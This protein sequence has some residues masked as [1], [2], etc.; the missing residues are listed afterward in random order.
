MKI[1]ESGMPEET[2]WESFF[3][4]QYIFS[5]L[6]LDSKINDAVEFGSG[7][8]TFTIPAAKIIKGT[9]FALDIDPAMIERLNQRIDETKL[10]N[11]KVINRDFVKEETGLKENSVDY[12]MLF[13]ILHAE[14][15]I[16]LLEESYRILKSNGK[17]GII[18]WIYSETTPRGP[19]MNIRP[20]PEQC[21]QWA[22]SAG[23]LIAKPVLLFHP[24]HYGILGLKT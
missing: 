9:L 17:L 12:V 3:D 19:S 24:Y 8:G 10:F 7:Y 20:K 6:Q 18:H 4:T 14:N 21:I 1:R 22:E 16:S 13:N 2:Y 23:F 15:P 5:Q 11:I